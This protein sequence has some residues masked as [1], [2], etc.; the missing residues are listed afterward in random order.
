MTFPIAD[1]WGAEASQEQNV[2]PFT[3]TSLLGQVHFV[4]LNKWISRIQAILIFQQQNSI[5]YSFYKINLIFI[6][7]PCCYSEKLLY[8]SVFLQKSELIMGWLYWVWIDFAELGSCCGNAYGIWRNIGNISL[9]NVQ[10]MWL[11]YYE[12]H[13]IS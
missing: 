9:V 10:I 1:Q 5:F 2:S 13:R 12:L 7:A 11:N 3:Y 4:L 6:L 8:S